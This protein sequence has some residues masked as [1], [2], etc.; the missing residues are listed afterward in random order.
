[1]QMLVK[2]LT[3]PSKTASTGQIILLFKFGEIYEEKKNSIEMLFILPNLILS[4]RRGK[5]AHFP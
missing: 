1:M 5:L 3:S 2:T 4:F